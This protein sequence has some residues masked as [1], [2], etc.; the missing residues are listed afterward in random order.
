VA[1]VV[2]GQE[3]LQSVPW[4]PDQSLPPLF[5]TFRQ[6]QDR[7]LREREKRLLSILQPMAWRKGEQ[8]RLAFIVDTDVL[9]GVVCLLLE[10]WF[11]LL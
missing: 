10:D 9:V 11:D 2:L 5:V 6:V 4:S 1:L 3:V 7:E 8:I